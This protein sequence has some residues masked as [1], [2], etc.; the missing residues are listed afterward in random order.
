VAQVEWQR[1]RARQRAELIAE[2]LREDVS[3]HDC[4][5]QTMVAQVAGKLLR[6][7]E[8]DDNEEMLYEQR[9][10][11]GIYRHDLENLTAFDHR[12]V[13]DIDTS[14]L[15]RDLEG[16]GGAWAGPRCGEPPGNSSSKNSTT[17]L[18][19]NL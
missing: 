3:W 4:W 1:T 11:W 13:E 18:C 7:E 10:Q 17:G 12:L 14:D 16:R 19:A 2:V 15:Y 5:R 8:T 9:T 6:G